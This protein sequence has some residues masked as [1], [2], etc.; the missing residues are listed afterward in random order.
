[1]ADMVEIHAIRDS[2]RSRRRCDVDITTCFFSLHGSGK[3]GATEVVDSAGKDNP[4]LLPSPVGASSLLLP[5]LVCMFSY[6]LP[7]HGKLAE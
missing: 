2:I 3:V 5:S 1:M 7:T 6:G 4:L